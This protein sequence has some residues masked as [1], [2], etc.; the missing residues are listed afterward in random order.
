MGK[1]YGSTVKL[2]VR[3]DQGLKETQNFTLY[4]GSDIVLLMSGSIEIEVE[5]KHL[6]ILVKELGYPSREMN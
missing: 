4:Y 1:H 5:R 3:T 6:D 2:T